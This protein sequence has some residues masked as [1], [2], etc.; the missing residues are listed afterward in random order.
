MGVEMKQKGHKIARSRKKQYELLA[1]HHPLPSQ[2]FLLFGDG[3]SD[4]RRGYEQEVRFN[5]WLE[6]L[7]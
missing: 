4:P 3:E 2:H 6:S 1:S 5:R 7:G